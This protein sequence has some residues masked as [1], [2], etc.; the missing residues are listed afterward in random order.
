MRLYTIK[1][2]I[3]RVAP[4]LLMDFIIYI[5]KIYK[6]DENNARYVEVN[7]A[8]NIDFKQ[9]FYSTSTPVFNIPLDKIRH[10]G[11]QAYSYSQHHFMYLQ[12]L[13]L[14]YFEMKPK[15]IFLSFF[16]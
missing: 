2:I 8:D 6:R 11:G 4:P 15:Y 14:V 10:H 7:K 3:F 16:Y 1:K 13:F 5:Y 9:I 12:L